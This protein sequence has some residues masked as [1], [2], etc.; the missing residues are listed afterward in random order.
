MHD[1]LFFEILSIFEPELENGEQKWEMV[2][3]LKRGTGFWYLP[4]GC[5][6]S[7]PRGAGDNPGVHDGTLMGS[8]SETQPGFWLFCKPSSVESNGVIV[9]QVLK[10]AFF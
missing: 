5:V 7:C 4:F 10:S 9:L 3:V 8:S 1:A 2:S 6:W